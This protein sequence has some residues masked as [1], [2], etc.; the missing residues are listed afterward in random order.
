MKEKESKKYVIMEPHIIFNTHL[1]PR[2]LFPSISLYSR[3]VFK[4]HKTKKGACAIRGTKCLL[5]IVASDVK[6]EITRGRI[7]RRKL[8]FLNIFK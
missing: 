1:P 8:L 5:L 3:I 6:K 4:T 2:S 7:R